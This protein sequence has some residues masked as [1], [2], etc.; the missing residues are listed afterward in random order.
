MTDLFSWLRKALITQE[1]SPLILSG[2]FHFQFVTIHPF[3]DGNGRLARLWSHYILSKHGFDFTLISAIEKQIEKKRSLYYEQLHQLQGNLFYNI[4]PQVDLTSWLEFWLE[5]L[6]QAGQEASQ[7]ITPEIAPSKEDF[8]TD[9]ITLAIQFFKK[10]RKLKASEYA[11][12]CQIGRT[13]A[14]EDLNFLTQKKIIRK[15][16]GGRSTTYIIN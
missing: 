10:H 3:M 6:Y 9:R 4:S 7:R 13:Q 11:D 1:I 15:I 5:C 16:G 8:P 14:V 2:I 12:L